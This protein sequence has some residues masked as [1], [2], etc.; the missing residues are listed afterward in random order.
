MSRQIMIE[1]P[2]PVYQQLEAL[3]ELDDRD[4]SALI[5]DEILAFVPQSAAHAHQHLMEQERLAFLA[6][7]EEL[8]QKYPYQY[9]AIHQ[10]KVVDHDIDQTA[11]LK[12]RVAQY[13]KQVVLIRQVLPVAE[14]TLLFRSPRIEKT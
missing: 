12:R 5:T 10:G 1:L 11:L 6:Q 14:R 3:A 8:W 2:E 9:V 7:H 4:V 13:G